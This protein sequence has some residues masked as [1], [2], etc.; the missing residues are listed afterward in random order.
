MH[1][2]TCSWLSGVLFL[3]VVATAAA[4]PAAA[5]ATDAFESLLAADRAWAQSAAGQSFPDA[6]ASALEDDAFVMLPRGR[7]ARGPAQL[8]AALAA[9]SGSRAQWYPTWGGG[10]ADGTQ[11]FTLGYLVV[12]PAEGAPLPGKYLA[13]WRH[14]PEGWRVVAYKRRPRAPGDVP[15]NVDAPL[16]TAATDGRHAPLADIIASVDA[17]E[18]AFSAAAQETS[19]SQAFASFG[20]PRAV[21]MGG[22]N[23][24][25]FVVGP[26]QIA[27]AVGEGGPAT[28]S[29]VS[30]W[31]DRIVAAASGDLAL[32]IGTL[33][34]NEA[35]TEAGVPREFPFFTVWYRAGGEGDWLYVAE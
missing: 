20:H 8:R 18:R 19:L 29:S 22:P 6:I 23:D 21:N 32:S 33:H 16:S 35:P 13:Y 31:P 15:G 2:Q 25:T 7:S 10:S 17:R 4:A 26:A 30:W 27:R 24:A 9:E 12:T 1:R 14:A 34:L 3:A 11:G 5:P 28:G